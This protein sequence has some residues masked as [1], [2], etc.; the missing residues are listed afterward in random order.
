M[1]TKREVL[2]AFE[3]FQKGLLGTVPAMYRD[4]AKKPLNRS[5]EGSKQ[6]SISTPETDLSNASDVLKVH[7]APT[8]MQEG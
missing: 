3:D 1:N 5:G 6:S 8:T 7:G 2:Q 4:D